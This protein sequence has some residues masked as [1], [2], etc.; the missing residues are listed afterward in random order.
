MQRGH[1]CKSHVPANAH[2]IEIL[3]GY[4]F[5]LQLPE[6]FTQSELFEKIASISYAGDFRQSF[7][8]DKKKVGSQR[9]SSRPTRLLQIPKLVTG[10]FQQF[11]D[12]YAPLLH[13]D[14]RVERLGTGRYQQDVST[15]AIYHRLNL[16]PATLLEDMV[17]SRGEQRRRSIFS[18]SHRLGRYVLVP[19]PE[20]SRRRR[21]RLSNGMLVER[22]INTKRVYNVAC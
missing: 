5:Q 14:T 11:S 12:I 17:S 19:R 21:D 20:T 2:H 8:E 22:C 13:A 6:S 16:L 18:L 1:K 15:P 4:D 10:A 3:L 9:A 7:A